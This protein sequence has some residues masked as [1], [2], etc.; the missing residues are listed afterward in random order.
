[1]KNTL[2]ILFIVVF[3]A[4]AFVV[5]KDRSQH[6]E[7]ALIEGQASSRSADIIMSS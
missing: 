1:M 5:N 6:S 2:L 3:I 7:N 4:G